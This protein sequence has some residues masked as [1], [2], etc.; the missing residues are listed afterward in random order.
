MAGYAETIDGCNYTE[1]SVRRRV[2]QMFNARISGET[3]AL[4]R[5]YMQYTEHVSRRCE[6]VERCLNLCLKEPAQYIE[7]IS[8]LY[9][10]QATESSSDIDIIEYMDNP[11]KTGRAAAKNIR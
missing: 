4:I 8:K 1:R 2:M 11:E 10:Y 9:L 7:E 6:I 3:P 5:Y